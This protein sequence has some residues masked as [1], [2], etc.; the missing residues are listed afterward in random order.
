MAS[1]RPAARQGPA[2]AVV[3]PVVVAAAV[4]GSAARAGPSA[5]PVEQTSRPPPAAAAAP[6]GPEPTETAPTATVLTVTVQAG[7][8]PP[9]TVPRGFATRDRSRS[10]VGPSGAVRTIR[11]A[12]REGAVGRSVVQR[13]VVGRS[14]SRLRKSPGRCPATAPHRV[15]A[16][17]SASRRPTARPD[18]TVRRQGARPRSRRAA[19]AVLMTVLLSVRTSGHPRAT[20]RLRGVPLTSALRSTD[21][22][23]TA[24]FPRGFPRARSNSPRRPATLPARHGPV[25]VCSYPPP[26]GCRPSTGCIPVSTGLRNTPLQARCSSLRPHSRGALPPHASVPKQYEPRVADRNPAQGSRGGR[27]RPRI[28]PLDRVLKRSRSAVDSNRMSASTAA[29]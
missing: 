3:V 12:T 28:Q 27:N 4:A 19:R 26:I 2:A 24:W 1:R 13:S 11:P 5:G 9:E 16:P 17:Q 10:A 25:P 15:T 20:G 22:P 14:T 7:A 23:P 6:T 21:P 8:G 29:G 18:R